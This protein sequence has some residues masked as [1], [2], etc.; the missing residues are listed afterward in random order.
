MKTTLRLAAASILGV[1]A[2]TGAALTAS[3]AAAQAPASN[4]MSKPASADATSIDNLIL[5]TYAV[6]SGPA[7]EKRD[8]NRFRA[9]FLPEARMTIVSLREGKLAFS[10]MTPEEYTTRSGANLEKNGF[11]ENEIKRRVDGYGQMATVS[12]VYESRR[13]ASD[14]K[15][16]ARGMNS[17]QLVNDGTRWWIANLMW[18]GENAGAQL[19][20][21]VFGKSPPPK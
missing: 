17:F 7:G 9:L 4:P 3:P 12:S 14:A 21:D 13:L 6:I 20:A 19:P 11:F 16:F 10:H 18:E 2:L 8:W 5:A 1:A 15:P